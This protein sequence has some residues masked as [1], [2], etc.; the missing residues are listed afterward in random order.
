MTQAV[1]SSET[2]GIAPAQVEALPH[3][4]PALDGI[5]AFAVLFVIYE[6]VAVLRSP[7]NHFHGWLGVDAFFVLSGFLITSLLF[8][9]ERLRGKIDMAAFYIRRAFRI[10]PLYWLVLLVYVVMLAK[11]HG[12]H[13]KWQE[14][15]NALPFFLT[16]NNDIPLLLMP[17]KVGTVFGLSWT[18]GVEEK[19]YFFWP[20]LCF[21]LFRT[22]RSR[23]WAGIGVYVASLLLTILSFKMG[24]AYAGL[25]AGAL[26]AAA[27]TSPALPYLR[28]AAKATPPFALLIALVVGFALVDR[29]IW[30]VFVFG[31]IISALII[32]LL[33]NPSWLSRF[34]SLAPFVWL[35]KRSYAMYLTQGF[36]VEA[37]LHLRKWTSPSSE[38]LLA[39]IAFGLSA[40]LSTL[41]HRFVEE[42]ARNLGKRLIMRRNADKARLA[43]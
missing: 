37:L 43:A 42:P 34:F 23:T 12:Q 39:L 5:R 36:A 8:R 29:N 6:H 4:F 35:G 25:A 1:L 40:V 28:R 20:L 22:F 18:L 15:K 21:V 10:L 41:L 31:W 19:F 24:R 11:S 3:Y 26:L 30:F 7:L 33:L 14:M 13:L 2:R 32:S 9:E 16:F 17:Q 38:I 27:F